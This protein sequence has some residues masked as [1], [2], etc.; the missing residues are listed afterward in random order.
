MKSYFSTNRV[1]AWTFAGVAAAAVFFACKKEVTT[2]TAPNNQSDNNTIAAVQ[3]EAV[4]SAMYGDLFETVSTVAISQGTA[5][6]GARQAQPS[7][8]LAE[9]APCPFAELLDATGDTWPKRVKIDFGTSCLDNYGNYRSG[10]LNVTF[11]G[12]LF[13]GTSS[14][15]VE[16]SNYKVNGKTVKGNLTI[17]NATYTK[18]TG[19]RYTLEVANGEVSLADTIIV[20]YATK[21]TVT[22][23]AGFDVN[24]PV[25]NPIDDVFSVEG[26]A[27]LSYNQGGPAGETANFT[28][29]TPLIKKWACEHISKGK[30]KVELNKITGVIEYTDTNIT[31]SGTATITVGDKSKEI[32]L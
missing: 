27:S 1:L 29:V 8:N 13:S 23:T 3:H 21:R 14:V 24:A 5:I 17:S 26:T 4:V 16:P 32:K 19:I 25:R 9:A 2:D 20:K 22:Q 31:C 6:P 30:L 28:T 15:V 11:N 10:V 18:T 12:P 7:G